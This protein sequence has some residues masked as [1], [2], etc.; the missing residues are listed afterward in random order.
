MFGAFA[1][2]NNDYFKSCTANP[3]PRNRFDLL[4]M[5]VLDS[6]QS[7]RSPDWLELFYGVTRLL[8]R[9][10]SYGELSNI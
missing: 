2:D 4:L 9:G 3:V 1:G 8:N 7:K 10:N 5:A 6:G